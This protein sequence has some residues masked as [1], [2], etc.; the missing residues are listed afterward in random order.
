MKIKLI[1]LLLSLMLIAGCG[2]S[3][4]PPSL[5]QY[6]VTLTW[7]DADAVIAGYNVYRETT[8]GTYTQINTSLVAPHSFV[9]SDVI[10][11]AT[12]QYVVTAVGAD[13]LE[14]IY[15]NSVQAVIP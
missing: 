13:G 11:G 6:S 8:N 12:Y 7:I 1:P 9:D 15:S 14:S 10:S 3:P 2:G 4:A 5:V